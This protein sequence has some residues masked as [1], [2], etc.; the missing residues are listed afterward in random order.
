MDL[1]GNA[2]L[3]EFDQGNKV[4]LVEVEEEAGDFEPEGIE[5]AT[6]SSFAS[7]VVEAELKLELLASSWYKINE[8][9]IHR[10]GN[11]RATGW[12]P[13]SGRYRKR[14]SGWCKEGRK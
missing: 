4:E 1:F 11:G 5:Q 13:S 7:G 14:N 8:R 3:C 6:R 2:A 9:R 10:S 12:S